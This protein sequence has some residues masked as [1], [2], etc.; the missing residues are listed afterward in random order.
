[1]HLG[2]SRCA[3]TTKLCYLPTMSN[4]SSVISAIA[5]R[6]LAPEPES[7]TPPYGMWSTGTRDVAD[8]HGTHLE[9]LHAARRAAS[10]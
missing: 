10:R 3:Q 6:T 9:R 4:R 8:H 7:F 2:P 5:E 1:M